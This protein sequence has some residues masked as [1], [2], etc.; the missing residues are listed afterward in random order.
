MLLKT[1]GLVD[2]LREALHKL[3]GRI[4]VAFVY[5]S[6]ARGEAGAASDVDLMVLGEAKFTE[7]VT[8]VQSVQ[9]QLG[10]EVN[11]TIYPVEEFREKARTGHHFL[12]RVLGEEKLFL[13]G[14]GHDLK[15]L[16]EERVAHRT[17]DRAAG[18]RR[19]AGHGRR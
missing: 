13:V 16:A 12:T 18:D 19:P 8:A 15:R 6:L 10:R 9:D 3:A 1:V 11:P 14:D 17:E 4:E 2:V 5:G 7:L